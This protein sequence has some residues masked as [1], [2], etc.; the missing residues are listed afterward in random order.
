MAVCSSSSLSVFSPNSLPKTSYNSEPSVINVKPSKA[1]Y[2]IR[3]C[4]NSCSRRG[5]RKLNAGGEL[6]FIEPDLNEDPVDRWATPGISPVCTLLNA[7]C[8]HKLCCRL[9]SFKNEKLHKYLFWDLYG[10]SSS[11]TCIMILTLK[12]LL[13]SAGRFYIWRVWWAPY[14]LRNRWQRSKVYFFIKL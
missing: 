9:V 5:F 3:P 4:A 7:H 13:L 1:S 10:A 14:F 11:L 8:M 2:N 6:H 12:Y